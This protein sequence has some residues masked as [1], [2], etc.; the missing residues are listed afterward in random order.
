MLS[1]INEITRKTIGIGDT[2]CKVMSSSRNSSHIANRSNTQH[3]MFLTEDKSSFKLAI[4]QYVSQWLR[5]MHEKLW[6]LE[7]SRKDINSIESVITNK[8]D[9]M[10]L[11]AQLV[12]DYLSKNVFFGGKEMKA[13]IDDIPKELSEFYREV[14]L[15][16]L[17]QLN[18]WSADRIRCIFGW[19][20][21]AKRPLK[22]IEFHSALIFSPGSSNVTNLV[23]QYVLDICE[24]LVEERPDTTLTFVHISVKE[25][26]QAQTADTINHVLLKNVS[27]FFSHR[28]EVLSLKRLKL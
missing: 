28:Q 8:A 22:R 2:I 14:L 13:S 20:A 26:V 6:Q 15:Q 5:L 16:I 25:Y 23:P 27:D 3:I 7:L 24:A 11:Y 18:P 12:L 21:F 19:I 4:R 10:F 9:G 1:L 17:V